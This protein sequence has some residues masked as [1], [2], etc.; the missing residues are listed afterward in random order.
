MDEKRT[1]EDI[2]ADMR[3]LV[4]ALKI[5][6][7]MAK[8]SVPDGK[9]ALAILAK[10]PDGAGQVTATFE[11]EQFLS[12]LALLVGMGEESVEADKV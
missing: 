1:T 7:E 3:C 4:A 8:L 9:P 2:K 6:V 5:A 12:D 11:I 10:K